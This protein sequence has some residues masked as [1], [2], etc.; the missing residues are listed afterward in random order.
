[1]ITSQY[2]QETRVRVVKSWLERKQL[3]GSLFQSL[4]VPMNRFSLGIITHVQEGTGQ[5]G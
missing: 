1:M 3:A 4:L 2:R 5:V